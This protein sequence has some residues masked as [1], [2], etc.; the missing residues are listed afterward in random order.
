M[1]KVAVIDYF[2]GNIFSITRALECLGCHVTLASTPHD[3]LSADYCVLPGVGAFGD[4]IS[5]LRDKGLD[6][7]MFDFIKTGKPFMGICLGMQLLFS[8]S[9][10]FGTH[11]GLN[12]INGKVLKLPENLGL[13]V[14]NIG[15]HPL[16]IPNGQSYDLSHTILRNFNLKSDLYFVHSFACYPSNPSEWLASTSYGG[17]SFCS[18]VR[19]DNVFGC[20]FHPEKSGPSGLSILKNFLNS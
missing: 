12:F 6:V 1:K 14:P 20:Q 15:W 8:T 13:K 10:E 17:H 18:V 4:G 5:I 2:S 9:E 11:N 19:K 16:T 7:A 3:I